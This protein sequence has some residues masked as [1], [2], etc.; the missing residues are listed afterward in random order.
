MLNLME[1]AQFVAFADCGTLSQVAE[2]LH[3]SQ[4]TI[5]R[6]MRH[7]EDAFG[8]A[9]F[10]RGKNKIALNE[11][12]EKAV[13][14][15][16]KLLLDAQAAVEAVQA[17]DRGRR[18]IRVASCAPAPLWS[19]L[20]ALTGKFPE[21]TIS[22]QILNRTDR[23]V[24]AVAAGQCDIG[25]LPFACPDAAFADFPYVRETLFACV[26][27]SNPLSAVESLTFAQLNGFNCLLR[28]QIGFWTDLCRQKM[29]SSRFLVQTDEFEFEE[30][31]QSSTLLSFI[32]NLANPRNQTPPGR[33]TIP[34][35]DAEA[36]VTY[37]LICLPEKK[38]LLRP[39]ST[40]TKAQ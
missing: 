37:H 5:T 16:R 40:A 21:N 22:S 18:T 9:L 23:I 11:T 2:T 29:P 20:P 38:Q 25:I 27:E 33:R 19:L 32:T 4:P 26:P 34:I 1:L 30:L 13:E 24:E 3:I 35:T 8:V 36:D 15:A 6:T 12:G 31:V 39:F 28:D 7:V 14:Y 17:F 10:H